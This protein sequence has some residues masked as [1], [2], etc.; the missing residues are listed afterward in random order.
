MKCIH[1]D[2]K[3]PKEFE[4]HLSFS[5]SMP[6]TI[7]I[8]KF[9][10]QDI[11]PFH[12][13][14][15]IEILVC[16]DLCGEIIIDGNYFKLKGKQV[17]I[18]P[19]Y[20]VHSNRIHVC[21]GTEYVL[22]I[23]FSDMEQYINI[24]LIASIDGNDIAN[25]CYECSEYD[26]IVQIIN[27]L[28]ANDGNTF[29]CISSISRIFEL[30]FLHAN[31][32]NRLFQ[33]STDWNKNELRKLIKWTQENHTDKITIDKASEIVGYSKYYFC[34][35]FKSLTGTTYLNYLNQVRLETA[36]R[37]LRKGESVS[38]ACYDSGYE[39]VSYFIQLFKKMYG[40]TPRKYT[41]T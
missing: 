37:I 10:T 39:N 20:T 35:W 21:D 22:K 24:P 7:R 29:S 18:I 34:S 41:K 33:N 27:D 25:L 9:L 17:F 3:A 31:K 4:E 28:I 30:F 36:C 8:K 1:Y 11:V 13:G 14:R 40:M 12:Y 16:Q 38:V 5:S 26:Q 2:Y 32:A 6:Y 19:P 15:T 23:S